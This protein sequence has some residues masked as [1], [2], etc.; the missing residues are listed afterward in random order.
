MQ[1]EPQPPAPAVVAVVVTCD[2]GPWFGETLASLA[3]QDYPNLAVLVIDSGSAKDPTEMVAQALPGAYVRRKVAK[4][5]FGRAANDVLTVVEGA[6]HYLFCHDDVVLAPDAVRLL[7]E[8]AFR[9]NSGI[10]TPKYVEWEHPDRLVAVGATADKVG[11]VRELVEPGELDQQQHDVV[12]EVLVA[13][14]GATLVRADLFHALDGFSAVDRP[15]RRGPGPVVAGPGGGRP[16]DGCS[17][18]PGPPP[19]GDPPRHAPGLGDTGGPPADGVRLGGSP[20][21]DH[22]DVLP[23]VRPGLG[24]SPGVRMELGRGGHEAVPGPAWSSVGHHDELPRR[25]WSTG[26]AVEGPPAPSTPSPNR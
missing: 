1:S 11:V 13:P 3:A 21:P 2:P 14:S 8:E 9:S 23:V 6:S 24:H 12:R 4:V 16:G 10:T 18:R 19:P 5:G 20:D 7:V 22:F 25:L 26:Q 15:V 17:G